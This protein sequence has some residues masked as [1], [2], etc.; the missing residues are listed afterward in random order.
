[1]CIKKRAEQTGPDVASR[2]L[3]QPR[4]ISPQAAMKN[5]CSKFNTV[6]HPPVL[7]RVI[8]APP[9]VCFA[10]R[11]EEKMSCIELISI[12]LILLNL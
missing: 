7:S 11:H 9:V 1:M 12:D 2:V 5:N 10:L 6:K 3:M 8:K 4:K